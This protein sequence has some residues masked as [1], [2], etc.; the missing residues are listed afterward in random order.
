MTCRR[1]QQAGTMYWPG[2]GARCSLT[3]STAGLLHLH[4]LN[5]DMTHEF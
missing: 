5:G 1:A 3:V 4:Q 2:E